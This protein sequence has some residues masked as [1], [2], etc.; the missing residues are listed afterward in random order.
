MLVS[1]DSN[2]I[3]GA[4]REDAWV[5]GITVLVLAGSAALIPQL[6]EIVPIHWDWRG[7]PDGFAPAWVGAT[8]LPIMA[9]VTYALALAAMALDPRRDNHER[10][11]GA[12]RVIRSSIPL[13]LLGL[14]VAIMAIYLGAEFSLLTALWPI[15]GAL[16]MSLGNVMGQLK[17]NWTVG[18]RV[19][20]TLDDEEVWRATHRFG[21]WLWFLGGLSLM[22]TPALPTE[23]Q[24]T[25][26]LSCLA[27]LTV[28][29][30]VYAYYAWQERHG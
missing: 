14:H 15:M 7:E 28:A 27:V 24:V 20:W 3:V 23:L 21:G 30:I 11:A 29:P 18:I 22:C 4:I 1:P 5:L 8:M 9:L 26:S 2:S 19:P 16:F 17:P 6:P 25:F 12:I 10:S 13:M